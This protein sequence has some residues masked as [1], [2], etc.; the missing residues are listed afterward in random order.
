MSLTG[1]EC[2]AEVF[3][4]FKKDEC[5]TD[6]E[7][8]LSCRLMDKSWLVSACVWGLLKTKDIYKRSTVI[9]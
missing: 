7:A 1:T 8:I 4:N 3:K 9:I 6:N 2:L 5:G